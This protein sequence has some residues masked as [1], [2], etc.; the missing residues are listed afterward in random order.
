M[1]AIFLLGVNFVRSQLLLLAI[2]LAYVLCLTAF[3]AFHEQLPD[4]LFFIRQQAI[5]GIALGAMVMVPAIQNERKTR[6]VLSVLSK[7]IHRWQYLGGLL[8]GAIFIAGIFCLA[9]GLSAVWLARQ[10]SMP[11]TGLAELMLILFLACAAGA[12]TALFCSVFLHPFLAL[13]ATALLLSFP[14]AAEANGWF[15]PH[16]LFPVFAALR[17]VLSFTF[18]KPGSGFWSIGIAALLHAVI[19]WLAASA[20]FARRDVTVAA[21]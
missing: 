20:I 1:K 8:C 10:A 19:F 4:L 9:V 6:R 3:L 7:G 12:S 17:V 11:V 15:L 16:Y 21:E 2:V 14:L 5:Y 18:Q 13:P